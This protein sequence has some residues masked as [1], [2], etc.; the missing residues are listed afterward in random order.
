[1]LTT[2]D[3]S[4]P[5]VNYL[6]AHLVNIVQFLLSNTES[7]LTSVEGVAL[8]GLGATLRGLE[9]RCCSPAV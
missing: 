3:G 8:L 6:A 7:H 1:M 5:N 4:N 9:V 2:Y